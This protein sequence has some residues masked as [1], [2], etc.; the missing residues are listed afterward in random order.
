MVFI[1]YRIF[2]I[3]QS[4]SMSGIPIES[5]K[6]C[7]HLFLRSLPHT[8]LFNIVGFGSSYYKTFPSSV[9]Y[10]GKNSQFFEKLKNV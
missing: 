2:V 8:C 9:P 5:A 7:L 10:N 6:A 1:F 4:G 3:D